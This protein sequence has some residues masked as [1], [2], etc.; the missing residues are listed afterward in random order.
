M[1]QTKIDPSHSKY[2]GLAEILF[3]PIFLHQTTLPCCCSREY[4]TILAL[5]Y[6]QKLP[7]YQYVYTPKIFPVI[8]IAKV[9]M[10]ITNQRFTFNFSVTVYGPNNLSTADVETIKGSIVTANQ[11]VQFDT[12]IEHR[13]RTFDSVRKY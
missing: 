9:H 10:T 5:A 11:T 2:T 4:Y 1:V 8:I 7:T 6:N 12:V 3:S 13:H